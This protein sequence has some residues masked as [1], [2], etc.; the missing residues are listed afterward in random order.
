M[1]LGGTGRREMAAVD[2]RACAQ[3]THRGD[4]GCAWIPH[5]P[6]ARQN[7]QVGAK[8]TLEEHRVSA[9]AIMGARAVQS[10][11]QAHPCDLVG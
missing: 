6:I 3:T 11:Q 5:P 4:G 10:M 8:A 9:A 7:A 2:R 1:A